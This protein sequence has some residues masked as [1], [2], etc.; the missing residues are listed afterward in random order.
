MADSQAVLTIKLE[1]QEAVERLE[2]ILRNFD[3]VAKVKELEFAVGQLER[4]MAE[5]LLRLS[6]LEE[7]V[8]D[9]ESWQESIQREG[10]EE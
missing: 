4:S 8:R 1:S 2:E 9:L 6:R 5:T 7:R 10:C 3:I